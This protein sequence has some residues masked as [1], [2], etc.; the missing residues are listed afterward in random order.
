MRRLIFSTLIKSR[1]LRLAGNP[2]KLAKLPTK[3]KIIVRLPRSVAIPSAGAKVNRITVDDIDSF[4][5]V[6]KIKFAGSLADSISETQFKNGVQKILGEPGIFKDW[7]GERSD[8]YSS[9]L[10]I[11]GKRRAAAFGF[12][13]P[14]QKGIL[15]PGRM[16]KNGD[17]MQ[18]LFQRGSRRVSRPTLAGN[19]FER[20]RI[21]AEFPPL[22]SRSRPESRSGTASSMGKILERLRAA[23]SLHFTA[24]K[25]AAKKHR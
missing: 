24:A 3:R 21:N 25:K 6:R 22:P 20:C 12:K 8:L 4:G 16:G 18:R 14:G 17:Q 23:Y 10:R 19:K 5:K 2:A 7:G 13:G 1:F 9:R 15:V 11:A